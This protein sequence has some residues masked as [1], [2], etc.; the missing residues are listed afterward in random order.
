MPAYSPAPARW[1][2][3]Q[4]DD[5]RP[6]CRGSCRADREPRTAHGRR[7][8]SK[9]VGRPN[10]ADRLADRRARRRGAPFAAAEHVPA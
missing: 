10:R 2:I 3:E 8:G 1:M 9:R 5:S 4:G 6:A 7:R